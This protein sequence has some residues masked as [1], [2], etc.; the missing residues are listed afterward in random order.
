[1]AGP[2]TPFELALNAA[3]AQDLETCQRLREFDGR[4][5]TVEVTDL[6]LRIRAHFADGRI[7]LQAGKTQDQADLHV[8]GSALSLLKLGHDPDQLFS[9]DIRIHGDVQFARQLQVVLDGFDFDWTA[10]LARFTGPTLAGPL[11]HGIRQGAGWLV[12]SLESLQHSGVEYLHEEA[13][14]LPNRIEIEDY[15][16]EVDMLRADGDR[17]EARIHRLLH[18]RNRARNSR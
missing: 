17:L 8:A 5:L 6:S 12:S 2:L 14:L 1:M 15:L 18:T 11:A 16:N 4:G 13:R 10:Q 9:S 3:L 7:A